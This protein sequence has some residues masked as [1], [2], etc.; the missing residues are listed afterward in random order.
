MPLN[1][2]D[3]ETD[4]L[5]RQ[6]AELTGETI[7]DA[8]RKAVAGRLEQERRRRSKTFDRTVLRRIQKAIADLP[9]A[10][11]RSPNELVGYDES[12]LPR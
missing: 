3:P 1:I 7:T 6:L 11:G 2:K 9:V 8:V 4:R 5:A 10:D 12:G